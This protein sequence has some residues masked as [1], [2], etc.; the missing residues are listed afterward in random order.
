VGRFQFRKIV[1]RKGC[2]ALA[3]HWARRGV[4]VA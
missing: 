3:I 4:I 2:N 1:H